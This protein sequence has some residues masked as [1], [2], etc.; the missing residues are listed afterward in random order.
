MNKVGIRI[1][2][3]NIEIKTQ[4]GTLNT[5]M[6]EPASAVW[7]RCVAPGSVGL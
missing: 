2:I 7:C 6:V 4:E 3:H 5:D 1:R